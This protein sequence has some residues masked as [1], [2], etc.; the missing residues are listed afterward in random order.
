MSK[1]RIITIVN[2]VLSVILLFG[3]FLPVTT[4][5]IYERNQVVSSIMIV[6]GILSIIVNAFDKKV[7]YSFITGGFCF[8]YS[9]NYGWGV[10]SFLNLGYYS[11]LFSSFFLLVLTVIYG[12]LKDEVVEE[13][14]KK[15]APVPKT[16]VPQQQRVNNGYRNNM[17]VPGRNNMNYNNRYK[18]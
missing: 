3:I 1:K 2:I 5:S 11:L 13:K 12:F 4:T 9:L 14:P 15:K 18:R 6:L 17:N 10:A 16:Q 7:E 8:F